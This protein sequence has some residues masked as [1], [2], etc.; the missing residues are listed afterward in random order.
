MERWNPHARIR[1]DL[2]G[3]IDVLAIRGDQTLAIQ[4]TSG[5]NVAHRLAKIRATPAAAAWLAGASRGIVI[6]GW[7][8]GGGRGEAKR[9]CCRTVEVTADDCKNA[10]P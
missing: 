4:A 2:F 10:N 3:F 7:R 9:W 5:S 6:H 8:K 1:Q